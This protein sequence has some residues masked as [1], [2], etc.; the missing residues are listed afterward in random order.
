MPSGAVR[1]LGERFDMS[2]HCRTTDWE[3]LEPDEHRRQLS[4][5]MQFLP[6][7]REGRV[8][9]LGC[10]SGRLLMPL[11]IAGHR[12]FGIDNDP[13]ALDACRDTLEDAPP[14]IQ[15]RLLHHNF[16]RSSKWPGE[17]RDAGGFDLV[18]CLG[19]TFMLVVDP[20]E[21]VALLKRIHDI[22]LPN[23]GVF[24]IDNIPGDLW[25]RVANGDWP[26]GVSDDRE[27]QMVWAPDDNVFTLR[28][29]AMN[30]DLHYDERFKEDDRLHRLWTK[31][32][33]RLLARASGF[34]NVEVI[35][36]AHLIV[37]HVTS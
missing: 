32:E 21:A 13:S 34:T 27:S 28:E 4:G 20:D 11:G 17:V 33:L 29:G 2:D 25:P 23:H 18:M 26:T 6:T 37:Y 31:G 19:H 35:E 30:V 12:C 8:L 9:D 14:D 24:V 5:L 7:E 3:P 36:S 1:G 15:V 16:I 10:G 22:L